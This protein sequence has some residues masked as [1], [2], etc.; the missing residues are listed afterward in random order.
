MPLKIKGTFKRKYNNKRRGVAKRYGTT[1][2]KANMSATV[3]QRAFKKYLYKE[4]ETKQSQSDISDYQQI[5][6]NS[7]KNIFPNNI[8]ATTPGVNDPT[9]GNTQNRI[10]DKITLLKCQIKMMLELNERYSDVTYRIIVT[11]SAR[12]DTP[13]IQ[14][15]FKG[16][17]GN[18]MLDEINYERYTVI[19]QRW[20]KIKAPNNS[21]SMGATESNTLASGVYYAPQYANV[22]SRAT[23]IVKIDIP[24]SRFAKGGVI[25]YE[26][27]ANSILQKFF[28]YNVFVYAYSNYS[29]SAPTSVSAGYNVLA[30]NDAFVRLFYK[31]L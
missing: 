3:I 15:L 20:G 10:G 7:F 2:A 14:T 17:S 30:V 24:G 18:K 21:A 26:G 13:T 12:G 28:D 19:Y 27:P 11:K 9:Q 1:V 4:A 5:E 29:T 16:L 25:Q 31:D 6:H 23:R 22:L 8:L